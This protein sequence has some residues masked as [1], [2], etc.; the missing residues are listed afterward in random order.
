MP[1]TC[2]II[3][4]TVYSLGKWRLIPGTEY[5]AS[6]NGEILNA[7]TNKKVLP[8]R[9]TKGYLQV[10]LVSKNEYVHRLVCKA[11]HGE[12]TFDKAQVD[13]ID[14]V[15]DNNKPSNLKWVT[16]KENVGNARTRWVSK[17]A[18]VYSDVPF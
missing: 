2:L 4:G 14:G 13:H 15:R 16:A 18:R 7:I 1:A 17:K 5:L 11:W 3:R 9:H 10:K 12:P 6:V 8:W